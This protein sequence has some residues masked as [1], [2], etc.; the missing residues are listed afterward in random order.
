MGW[1]YLGQL[2]E[3]FGLE[4][5]N[6]LL[7]VRTIAQLWISVPTYRNSLNDEVNIREILKLGAGGQASTR[8]ICIFLRQPS[9]SHVFRQ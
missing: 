8:C 7:I 2:R 3:D 1:A 4:V 6:F 5:W 9:L